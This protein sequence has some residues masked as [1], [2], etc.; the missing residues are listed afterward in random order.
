MVKLDDYLE[1]FENVIWRGKPVKKAMMLESCGG[2]P[3]ALFF[4]SLYLFYS[5]NVGYY[6]LLMTLFVIPWVIGLIF[7]PTLGQLIQLS[8][9]EYILTN[10][11]FIVKKGKKKEDIWSVRLEKVKEVIVK[12]G[13]TGKILGT[14]IVYPVTDS[15]PYYPRHRYHTRAGLHHLKN[16]YKIQKIFEDEIF[17]YTNCKYCH[18]RYD[19]SKE[20]KCPKCGTINQKRY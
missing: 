20:E 1:S 6:D 12:K 2:I 15:W 19:L 11:R 9:F 18:Y 3:F 13:I 17:E 16:P 10:Q 14:A 8:K 4:L 5:Y 7:L